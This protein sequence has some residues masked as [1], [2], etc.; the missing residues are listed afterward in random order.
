MKGIY[1]FE[2]CQEESALRPALPDTTFR[3]STRPFTFNTFG[4]SYRKN[5]HTFKANEI[6][7]LLMWM[8]LDSTSWPQGTVHPLLKRIAYRFQE[9]K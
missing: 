8:Y 2:R 4:E 9:L 1:W 5:L 3:S 7:S 6:L